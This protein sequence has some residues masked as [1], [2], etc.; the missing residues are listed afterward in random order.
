MNI[1]H[2]QNS[3]EPD[4][5]QQVTKLQKQIEETEQ[6]VKDTLQEMKQKY[7]ST[8]PTVIVVNHLLKSRK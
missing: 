2:R 7:G 8:V 5:E 6:Q 4:L 1:F 3:T